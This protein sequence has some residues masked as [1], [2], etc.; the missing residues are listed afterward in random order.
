LRGGQLFAWLHPL[1]QPGQSL[2]F[3]ISFPRGRYDAVERL[4][5]PGS[6]TP[7]LVGFRFHAG[8]DNWPAKCVHVRATKKA[9][10]IHDLTGHMQQKFFTA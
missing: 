4:Q 7:F 2:P 1:A 5:E 8:H 9:A 3:R 10:N 6:G